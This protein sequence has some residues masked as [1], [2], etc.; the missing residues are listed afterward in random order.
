MYT[1]YIYLCNE[2]FDTTVQRPVLSSRFWIKK[3]NQK[4]KRGCVLVSVQVNVPWSRAV[5]R[6]CPDCV[7]LFFSLFYVYT[8][9]FFFWAP[10]LIPPH[11][12][13]SAAAPPISSSCE[14]GWIS[15]LLVGHYV[16]VMYILYTTIYRA[17]SIW[18]IRGGQRSPENRTKGD[19]RS[20]LSGAT[21][22]VPR[23]FMYSTSDMRAPLLLLF[24]W[25]YKKR[26]AAL[27]LVE[28]YITNNSENKFVVALERER[29]KKILTV[30][31]M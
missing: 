15:F 14:W 16:R 7:N 11:P 1:V 12:S 22:A 20:S 8:I 30:F 21:K 6:R 9:F 13:F 23:L 26:G 2:W 10:L 24:F 19:P 27:L 5:Y 3:E 28:L 29:E 4:G 25:K 18:P 17:R 31:Q